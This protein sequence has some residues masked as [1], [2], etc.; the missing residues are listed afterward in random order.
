MADRLSAEARSRIMSS[1]R[2]KNTKPELTVRRLLFA[3]GYR[4][5]LHDVLLPG[6]PDIVFPGRRKV[7]FIHGCFWHQHEKATC[8]IRGKP[9]SNTQYWLP[10][11]ERNAARDKENRSALKQ[12]GWRSF[13]VWECEVKG[14]IEKTI[15]KIATFL[16]PPGK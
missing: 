7:V 1:I 6:K 9:T 12:L 5:R 8:P 2:E 3:A 13:V 15:T 11:L 16:G 4:F 10:K 14:S